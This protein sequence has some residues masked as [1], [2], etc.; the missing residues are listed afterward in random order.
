MTPRLLPPLSR[1]L[2]AA[3]AVALGVALVADSLREAIPAEPLEPGRPVTREIGP[4]EVHAYEIDLP[5]GSVLRAIVEQ[6]GADV[7]V[8]VLRP[9]RRRL[10]QLDGPTLDL[11]PEVVVLVAELAGP[12]RLEIRGGEHTGRYTLLASPP[13]PAEEHDRAAAEAAVRLAEA[14]RDAGKG[15]PD[16]A[17]EHVEAALAAAE[18][19]G[20]SVLASL[21]R[22]QRGQLAKRRDWKAAV[23]DFE[24]VLPA[25]SGRP[26][27]VL[28]LLWAGR[29]R[30]HADE[31]EAAAETFYK[32]IELAEGHDDLRR[33]EAAGLLNL[34]SA[35][36]FLGELDGAGT[37]LSAAREL[38]RELGSAVEEAQ[39]LIS[40]GDLEFL[41]GRTE[42][43]HVH[44]LEGLDRARRSGSRTMI[45]TLL[46]KVGVAR[47]ERGLDG[48]GLP[49]LR[50]ARRIAPPTAV[51][52]L[53]LGSVLL[54][55]G[56]PQGA[57]AA[58]ESAERLADDDRRAAAFAATSAAYA[59]DL[60]GRGEAAV[61]RYREVWPLLEEIGDAG[62]I[63]SARFGLARALAGLGRF[64]EAWQELEPSLSQ[65]EEL[66]SSA[67]DI[68]ARIAFFVSKREV[69]E[70]A[71]RLLV[72]LDRPER[73]F[74]VVERTR[75][76]AL[77][78]E[79][80]EAAPSS[81]SAAD[82]LDGVRA[83][84]ERLRQLDLQR[85]SLGKAAA[86]RLGAE[87]RSADLELARAKAEVRR[88]DP[89]RADLADPVPLDLEAVQGLLDADT[90]LLL[91]A[92]GEPESF[93]WIVG[94]EM[95]RL[96]RLPARGRIED[97]VDRAYAHLSNRVPREDGSLRELSRALVPDGI[98]AE[99]R[100]VVAADGA[101][102]AFP[103]QALFG[104]E[105]PEGEAR[106][107]V[108][109]HEIVSIPSATVLD[110]LRRDRPG[111]RS[112]PTV[113]VFADPVFTAD[114]ER[115]TQ[116][117]GAVLAT[118]GA[119]RGTTLSL[120]LSGAA[121]AADLALPR[122]RGSAAE[123]RAI[124]A[125]VPPDRAFH[126]IG[127][128]ATR[129]A[130]M[131]PEL[132]RFS[133]LHFATHSLP[134]RQHPGLFALVFARF[135]ALGRPRPDHLLRA[136]EIYG[137]DLPADLVVLSA[138]ETGVGR[139]TWGEGLLGLSRAFLYAGARAV[140][141]SLWPISD[142]STP[143]LMEIF[144]RRMLVEGLRPAAALRAAQRELRKRPGR[145]APYHWAGF[146]LQGDWK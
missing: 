32:A 5:A 104:P 92:L 76:R 30:Y 118:G 42:T 75:S 112:E 47:R 117:G 114:D 137:L 7:E 109:D 97:L 49:E 145:E 143:E 39:C 133:I 121:D 52:E 43:A 34:G 56:D 16:E 17:Q 129:E 2:L 19:A 35:L 1:S 86:D 94:P 37:H 78:D 146:V 111:H 93:L 29:C 11:G 85:R 9:W 96:E 134:D 142:T 77:A 108:E 95:L 55:R 14:V 90:L 83:A 31:F 66:R 69:W 21:V 132:A 51:L 89:R 12:Y 107:L 18:R 113:A 105:A 116:Q 70:L 27:E 33:H 119:E 41:L 130:A 13:R 54:R 4:E 59:C 44:Y 67:L 100:L 88:R 82:L 28:L 68:D 140:V 58:F 141:V 87:I 23:A 102:Q 138:C 80:A 101:L 103:F 26:E 48:L 45:A 84:E 24:A 10:L 91:Y 40:L 50:E 65:L 106:P 122:L 98:P 25:W 81:A 3:S 20:D 126:A 61:T 136:Y 36:L 127:F 22:V 123:A 46:R 124:L 57:L 63:A 60:L 115:L 8:T 72:E 120:R 139:E 64:E 131:S 62:S 73:A 38:Y 53:S 110:L 15:R 135:D 128:E 99:A 79:L 74:E 144:Y 71:T 6:L 125:L